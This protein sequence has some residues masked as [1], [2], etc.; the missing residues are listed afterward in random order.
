MKKRYIVLIAIPPA[1]IIGLL[2][3]A[4]FVFGEDEEALD[5]SPMDVEIGPQDPAI[6]GFSR[7]YEIAEKRGWDMDQLDDYDLDRHVDLDP[8]APDA[9]E[10]SPTMIRGFIEANQ[11]ATDAVNEALAMEVF[12]F[13]QPIDSETT[14]PQ[15]GLM[16]NYARTL[17]LKSRLLAAEGKPGEALAMLIENGRRIRQMA[18]VG[19]GLVSFL[20]AAD[21]AEQCND[22]IIYLLGHHAMPVEALRNALQHYPL[23]D[24]LT[25]SAALA[26]KFEY[27]YACSRLDRATATTD[28]WAIEDIEIKTNSRMKHLLYKPHKTKNVFFR[29]YH[30]L[31]EEL[32]LPLSQRD[33]TWFNE[34]T[35]SSPSNKDMLMTGNYLGEMFYKSLVPDIAYVFAKATQSDFYNEATYLYLAIALYRQEHGQLPPTLDALAPHYIDAVPTDPFDGEPIRYDAQRAILYSAGN[36]FVDDG[37]SAFISRF[38]REEPNF[39]ITF[40]DELI[41]EM[42]AAEPTIHI[43]FD[44]KPAEENSPAQAN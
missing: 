34:I 20:T 30:T 17:I 8:F 31:L 44:Q 43:R 12:E 15:L 32:K 36:D 25:D 5:Y 22:E 2:V 35:A 13:D 40:E 10:K 3:L 39:A 9:K 27:Q 37:G 19:G 26:I 11:E 42:D 21:L 4:V 38:D 18:E 7:L 33:F 41:A 23:R 29:R 28:R 24:F 6:N 14:L 1:C 16:R